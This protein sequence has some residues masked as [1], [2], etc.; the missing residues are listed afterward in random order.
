M[1][2]TYALTFPSFGQL[3]S[4]PLQ[5]RNSLDGSPAARH[6]FPPAGPSAAA[7]A[8]TTF[9]NVHAEDARRHSMQFRKQELIVSVNETGFGT[10]FFLYFSGRC[11]RFLPSF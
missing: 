8:V 11:P 10:E 4:F 7:P 5:T 6:F 3:H 9:D 2:P 1:G